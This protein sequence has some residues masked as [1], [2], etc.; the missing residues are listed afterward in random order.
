MYPTDLTVLTARALADFRSQAQDAYTTLFASVTEDTVTDEQ[1]AELR[2]LRDFTASVDTELA[3][4]TDRSTQFTSLP[5]DLTVAAT[6]VETP[7]AEAAP[8]E[9]VVDPAP[10][11]VTASVTEPVIQVS[12][13]DIVAPGSTVAPS[14]PEQPI[15][16]TLVAAA[17]VPNFP[18]GAQLTTMADVARAFVART[19][20][21]QGMNRGGRDS[22][23]VISSHGVAVLRREYPAELTV[24]DTEGDQAVLQYAIDQSRLPGRTLVA[25][26]ASRRAALL[27]SGRSL[28]A[29]VGWCAPSTTTYE[30]CLQVTTDGLAD[31][32]EVAAPRGGIRHNTG[33]EWGDVYGDGTGFFNYSEAQI[34]SGVSKGCL[35][36]NCPSF[37][38]TRLGVTGLCLTGN[39]LQNRA[40][41]EYVDTF[42]RGA[43]AASAHQVNM[44]QIAAVVAAST[45]VDVTAAAPW[46]GDGT[47]MSQL[48][49]VLDMAA[50]DI[51]YKLRLMHDAPLEVKLPFWIL[52][53][54]RADWS[55]RNAVSTNPNLADAEV[56]AWFSNRNINVQFVYDWQDAFSTS[57][58]GLGQASPLTA[59]P[60]QVQF[61]MY[62]LGTWVRAVSDVITL[63]S[64]YDSTKLASNQVTQLFTEQGWAMVRMCTTSRVYT[65][66]V[67]PSGETGAQRVSTNTIVC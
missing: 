60:T 18:T 30:T 33:I 35:V 25:S 22:A 7:P 49:G 10:A 28:V 61:L 19:S 39:I 42:M 56:A 8:V 21:Y 27:E 40:Y 32:P 29:A 9:P 50:Y 14:L 59:L 17:D 38:D 2:T 46:V 53:Q 67:C 47:V 62:P 6:P 23:P 57:G 4:R 43:M 66:N 58:V 20:G 37:T 54:F 48:F 63:N 55:R 16:A 3:S 1:L 65:V 41:P 11:V 26:T 45:A 31:W 52:A 12:I 64:I 44:L 36:I 51:R 34:I 24:T 13:S 5:A 15:Y